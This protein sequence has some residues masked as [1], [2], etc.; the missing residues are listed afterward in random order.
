MAG[1]CEYGNET[2]GGFHKMWGISLLSEDLL[3]SQGL[4]SMEL[5]M[6]VADWNWRSSCPT[7]YERTA[8]VK[9]SGKDV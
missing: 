2:P 3:A 1:S 6:Y 4:C 7:E 8:K 9:S 5:V